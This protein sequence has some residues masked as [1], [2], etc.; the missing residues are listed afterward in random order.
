MA[1]AS[2]LLLALLAAASAV[3]CV[4]GS[5]LLRLSSAA[6]AAAAPMVDAS[7]N[8]S[9][10][11]C[12]TGAA[13]AASPAVVEYVLSGS[14]DVC[15]FYPLPIVGSC[16]ELDSLVP[17]GRTRCFTFPAAG[18][19]GARSSANYTV[20]VAMGV[21]H[22]NALSWTVTVFSAPNCEGAPVAAPYTSAAAPFPAFSGQWH[23]FTDGHM[24]KDGLDGKPLLPSDGYI[25]VQLQLNLAV[26][27]APDAPVKEDGPDVQPLA[28]VL[29]CA[30]VILLAFI[31]GTST[32]KS[33]QQTKSAPAGL[34]GGVTVAAGAY[35]TL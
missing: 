3:A 22:E 26:V 34:V 13:A 11:S 30:A 25:N 23:N 29:I 27:G 31:C 35:G 20:R 32:M 1:R 12:S 19:D 14:A 5:P 16:L 7:S 2:L 33:W 15:E 9:S 8:S 18:P 6:A 4:S 17:M 28:A 21:A 10:S 24:F